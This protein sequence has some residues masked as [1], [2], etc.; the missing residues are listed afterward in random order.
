VVVEQNGPGDHNRIIVGADY[1]EGGVLGALVAKAPALEQ[2]TVPSAP[3]ASF[4]AVKD[5]PLRY[6]NVDAGYDTQGFVGNLAASCCFQGLSGLELG[7]F[8]ETYLE[9]FASRCTPTEDYRRLFTSRAFA[10]VA[11]FTWRNPVCSEREIE[12]LRALCAKK[13]QFRLVRF[14]ARYV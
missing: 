12:Q 3:D 8:N 13:M 2:L 6:L 5:H 4:F 10:S 1:E 9:E 11:T 7:E 14:S